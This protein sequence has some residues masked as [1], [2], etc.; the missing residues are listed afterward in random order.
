[1]RGKHFFTPKS[2]KVR[3]RH[4]SKLAESAK[5]RSGGKPKKPKSGTQKQCPK[6]FRFLS[7]TFFFGNKNALGHAVQHDHRVND[8]LRQD[9]LPLDASR[10]GI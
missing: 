7:A 8:G 3:I 5:V 1:M 10:D 9:V 2:K 4:F 6:F